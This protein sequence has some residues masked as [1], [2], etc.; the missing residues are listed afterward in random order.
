MSGHSL[1]P[2]GQ[3]SERAPSGP[4]FPQSDRPRRHAD[5]DFLKSK[6][7]RVDEPHVR[8]LNDLARRIRRETGAEVPWFDPA[9]G[10]VGARALLLL[11]APGRRSTSATSGSGAGG[12]SGIISADNNDPT[13]AFSWQLYRDCRLPLDRIVIWNAVPWHVGTDQKIR[14]ASGEDVERA[15]PHLRQLVELLPDLRVTLTMGSRARDGWLRFLLAPDVPLVPTLACPHPNGR[16]RASRPEAE[17]AIRRAVER[18]ASVITDG[19]AAGGPG[20]TPRG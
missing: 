20:L 4:P 18:V 7:D 5:Q 9:N 16:N 6:L 1:P 11:E 10:G 13:A 2:T 8:P 15:A 17:V 14:S 12:G 3:S 19:A